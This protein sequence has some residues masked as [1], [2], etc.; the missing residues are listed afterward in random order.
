MTTIDMIGHAAMSTLTMFIMDQL[1]AWH[2]RV[3]EGSK[4]CQMEPGSETPALEA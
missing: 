2:E 1:V 4:C 3:R